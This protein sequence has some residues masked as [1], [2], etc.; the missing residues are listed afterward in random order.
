MYVSSFL[1]K[2]FV[3]GL[4]VFVSNSTVVVQIKLVIIIIII[5][6]TIS[7]ITFWANQV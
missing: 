1:I 5:L 4:G 2:V 6:L 3:G 7:L